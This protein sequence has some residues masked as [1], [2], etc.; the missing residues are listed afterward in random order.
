MAEP[1]KQQQRR[2]QRDRTVPIHVLSQNAWIT[3]QHLRGR[4][5]A[6]P[7]VIG[8]GRVLHVYVTL[9]CPTSLNTFN[10]PLWTDML[11]M[12]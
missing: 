6:L 9:K 11:V 10:K 3:M 2:A 7:K 5:P 12:N 8:R 1:R 4:Q